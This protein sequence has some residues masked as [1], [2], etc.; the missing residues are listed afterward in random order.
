[1]LS[2]KSPELNQAQPPRFVDAKACRSWLTALP[3]AN[4]HLAHAEIATQ[5]G[6]LN[7][8]PIA[9]LERLL[10][11]EALREPVTFLQQEMAKE[12]IGRPLPLDLPHQAVWN[13]AYA[14]WRAMG[15]AY[16]LCLQGL[17]PRAQEEPGRVALVCHRCLRYAGLQIAEHYRTYRQ[18]PGDLWQ[19]L[20]D[21]YSFAEE[22]DLGSRAVE[23]PLN[24]QAN[25]SHCMAAYTQALMLDLADPYRLAPRELATLER[26]LEKWA[27]RVEVLPAPPADSS[28]SLVGVDLEGAS[29][30][31]ILHQDQPMQRPRYLDTERFGATFRKRI[32]A[33]RKGD[34]P[35]RIGLGQDCTQP[36]CE[37]LLVALYRHWC[38]AVVKK[39]V[40]NRRPGVTQAQ[41]S[42]GMPALHFFVSG[43]KPFRQPGETG[44]LSQ[45]EVEDLAL[46]GRVS[47]R[48]ERMRVSQ[49]GFALET[50]KIQDESAL[51]FRLARPAEGMRLS[52]K[53]LLGVRPSDGKYFALGV[54]KWLIFTLDGE[55]HVG[56]RTLPGVPL[57]LAARPATLPATAEKFVQ[58][59]LLP[60]MPVLRETAS[61]LIPR[62]WFQ[63]GRV[64]EIYGDR[65][66]MVRLH[67]LVETGADYERVGFVKV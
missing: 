46:F 5:L 41:V 4:T 63:P 67:A 3:L 54:V 21:L 53:Q 20:H 50:W 7:A 14:L 47:T 64:L 25:G 2:L 36:G 56:M 27:G 9:P 37:A 8:Y 6:L 26:W 45:R 30:P 58:A 11:L 10:I 40:F 19:Q 33:L 55:L 43:E 22:R 48:T 29:G 39:R 31:V 51:G 62:G 1:M 38:E 65:S 23:D 13:S 52:Y 28:L 32:K 17:A 61:L 59:F 66:E 34:S 35:E 57:P 18:V 60:E 44:R 24:R 12:Y 15:A 49:L 42:V 16:L